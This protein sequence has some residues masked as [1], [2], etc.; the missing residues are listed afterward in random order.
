MDIGKPGVWF[1]LDALPG[2]ESVEHCHRP[3]VGGDWG[4]DMN[5]SPW[6]REALEDLERV[7]S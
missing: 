5:K 1:F 4:R 2:L 3:D 6:S 7:T